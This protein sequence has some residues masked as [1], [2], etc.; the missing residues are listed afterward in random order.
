MKQNVKFYKTVCAIIKPFLK[1]FYPYEV[2]GRE[3]IENLPDGYILCSNHLSNVDPLF[4]AVEHTKPICL[5][6]WV[7]SNT[8]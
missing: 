1:V 8:T 5:N 4:L 7:S 3:N 6:Y 2:R